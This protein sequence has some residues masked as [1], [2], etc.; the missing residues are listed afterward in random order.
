M[1]KYFYIFDVFSILFCVFCFYYFSKKSIFFSFILGV[2]GILISLIIN[3]LLICKIFTFLFTVL[4]LLIGIFLSFYFCRNIT[5]INIPELIAILHSF[6]GLSSFLISINDIY[7][8]YILKNYLTK[9]YLFELYLNNVTSSITFICSAFSYFILTNNSYF[10]KNFYINNKNIKYIN[11]IILLILC[12]IFLSLSTFKNIIL[13]FFII[14]MCSLILGINLISNVKSSNIPIFIS[15]LNSCSG[16]SAMFSGFLLKNNLLIVIGSIVGFSGFFLAHEMCKSMKQSVLKVIFSGFFCFKGIKLYKKKL[17]LKRNTVF[18]FI[19]INEV[20]RETMSAQSIIIV[21]GYGM[22][23]SQAHFI[24]SD[25][26]NILRK[27]FSV[28]KIRFAIHP[29]AGRLPGHMNILLSEARIDSN[30]IYNLHDINSYFKNTDLVII[31][32]A[33]DIVN[34]RA[35]YDKKCSLY[36][37]PVLKVWESKKLII[38]KRSVNLNTGYTNI[39]NPLFSNKNSRILLGDAKYNLTKLFQKILEQ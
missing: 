34:P 16:W 24:V 5:I 10:L 21:P 28:K 20:V 11:I 14:F 6:V 26:I 25:I 15:I 22:A 35:C 32:G 17:N 9:F 36:T 39:Y 1:T 3:L 18:N 2:I 31:I 29:V 37:M 12:L 33:S 38:L 30:T 19:N 4:I 8:L 27:K 23:I 7:T 13:C